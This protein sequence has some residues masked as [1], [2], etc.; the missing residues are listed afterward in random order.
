MPQ[1][2]YYVTTTGLA[3][4]LVGLLAWLGQAMHKKT[5]SLGKEINQGITEL[6][7]KIDAMSIDI[8]ENIIDLRERVLILEMR[9]EMGMNGNRKEG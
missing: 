4:I 3:A 1:D 5:I 9:D 6:N 7:R 8:R 2:F